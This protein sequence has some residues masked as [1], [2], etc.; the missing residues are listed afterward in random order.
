M[1]QGRNLAYPLTHWP[2]RPVVPPD[3]LVP[4]VRLVDDDVLLFGTNDYVSDTQQVALPDEAYLREFCTLDSTDLNAVLSFCERYGP[5]GWSDHSDLPGEVIE[6]MYFRT[7]DTYHLPHPWDMVE[8][9][10][11]RGDLRD[12]LHKI[13]AENVA[14]PLPFKSIRRVQRA[15]EIRLYHGVFL[16]LVELWQ[17][18]LEGRDAEGLQDNWHTDYWDPP[19]G[20]G[21]SIRSADPVSKLVR[22]L[23]PALSAFHVRLEE[24]DDSEPVLGNV[25]AVLCLQLANH[26]AERA[27]Y[28]RC[29]A[30]GCGQLFVRQRGPD[31]DRH[32]TRGVLHFCS[33][34]C[35]NRQAQSN[36]RALNRRLA[37]QALVLCEE[38][39]STAE[40]ATR[41]NRRERQVQAWLHGRS[42]PR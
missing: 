8:D 30:T 7:D 29:A 5:V 13:L 27:T 6:N 1:E 16:D 24:G 4:Q 17:T 42:R 12:D 36:H 26:I 10:L 40:I 38:G 11:R 9:E 14:K 21:S 39:V 20:E 31:R 35:A 23:N 25:Y 33:D 15:S 32:R 22:G 18:V 19:R 37:K 3:V 41:L 28:R 34:D 2:G